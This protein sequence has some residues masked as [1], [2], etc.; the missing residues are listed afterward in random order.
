VE[1]SDLRTLRPLPARDAVEIL[2]QT[3][4]PHHCVTVRLATAADA[5]RAIRTMAVRG[6]PL[7]GATAA[8]GLALGLATDPSDSNLGHAHEL[9]LATRPTAVN[10]RWALDRVRAKVAPL[11]DLRAAAAWT[12]PTRSR[13]RTS[14]PTTRSAGM[15]LD[16]GASPP[17]AHAGADPHPLQRRRARHARLGY[18]D[19]PHLSRARGRN[20][21]P[22]LGQRDAA[23]T[24]RRQADR[25]GIA[26]LAACRTP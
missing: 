6:A 14:P 3:R 7:I 25:V 15:G 17:R 21:G 18:R 26:A 10:L 5:A 16:Q 23:E 2:D 22:R 9:L 19:R 8:Y 11:P 1:T 12:K 20:P 13:R 4:L 24:A